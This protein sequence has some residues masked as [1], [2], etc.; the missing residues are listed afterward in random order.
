MCLL[1]QAYRKLAASLHPDR[2]RTNDDRTAAAFMRVV[3]AYEVLNNR[4]SREE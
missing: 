3:T 2:Q 4:E 1:V